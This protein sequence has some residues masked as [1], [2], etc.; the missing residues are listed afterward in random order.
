MQFSNEG[1]TTGTRSLPGCL[2]GSR[3]SETGLAQNC[4]SVSARATDEGLRRRRWRKAAP[5][6]GEAPGRTTST[7]F[8]WILKPAGSAQFAAMKMASPKPVR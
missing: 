6:A 7:C 1:L 5:H 3:E 4:L 2:Q 8:Q